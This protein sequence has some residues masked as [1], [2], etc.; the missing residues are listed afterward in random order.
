M[1]CERIRAGL[2][3]YEHYRIEKTPHAYTCKKN[4]KMRG[5]LLCPGQRPHFVSIWIVVNLHTGEQ[6]RDFRSLRF[7]KQYAA[8]QLA[9]IKER[10]NRTVSLIEAYK[11][12]ADESSEREYAELPEGRNNY[13]ITS[14]KQA[15]DK[16]GR[17]YIRIALESSEGKGSTLL[18]LEPSPNSN[19]S[20]WESV[21]ASNMY[22]LGFDATKYATDDQ[23]RLQFARYAL[24]LTGAVVDTRVKH[25]GKYVNVYFDNLV[26]TGKPSADDLIVDGFDG[27]YVDDDL[28]V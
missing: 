14:V 20:V 8:D 16:N 11:K 27:E 3:A 13:K 28:I 25:N 17:T 23:A 21:L 15:D 26:S 12:A 1:A 2:Y 5:G 10:E 6:E 9:I 18:Y 22:G 19:V 24:S 4:H 7:A